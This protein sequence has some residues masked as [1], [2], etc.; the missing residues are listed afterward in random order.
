MFYLTHKWKLW[1]LQRKRRRI[2]KSF[3]AKFELLNK[4]QKAG[5]Y[6][7]AEL[8]ADEYYENQNM[9]EWIDA[10]RSSYLI[11]QA[12]ECDVETPPVSDASEFWQYTDDRENW[13]LN[14]KGRDL[15]QELINKKKA[16]TSANWERQVK[17]WATILGALAAFCGAATGVILALKK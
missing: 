12:I 5:P 9:D 10:F 1:M 7:A 2:Q 15:V 16:L 8:Q 6:D 3:A 17:N 11:D 14:R 13:Y 4:N